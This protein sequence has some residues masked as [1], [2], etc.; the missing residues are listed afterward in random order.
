MKNWF[1]KEKTYVRKIKHAYKR[2]LNQNLNCKERLFVD[3]RQYIFFII[4]QNSKFNEYKRLLMI[5]AKMVKNRNK[6]S[7]GK[8]LVSIL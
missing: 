1:S 4:K 7:A 3:I 6:E 8:V 2:F 5:K